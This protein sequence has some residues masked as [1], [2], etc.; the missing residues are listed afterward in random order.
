MG[1]VSAMGSVKCASQEGQG[2]D[3]MLDISRLQENGR[4]IVER[5]DSLV[6]LLPKVRLGFRQGLTGGGNGLV[7]LPESGKSTTEKVGT[8]HEVNVVITS[9]ANAQFVS[10]QSKCTLVVA[11]FPDGSGKVRE[12]EGDVGMVRAK[13]VLGPSEFQAAQVVGFRIL[14]LMLEKPRAVD[15]TGDGPNVP[16]TMDC[17]VDG[18][19]LSK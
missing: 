10:K 18:Q 7:V 11:Q 8:P 13:D 14:V 1:R 19:S 17:L 15:N 5:R 16:N 3:A 4:Q 9:L 6:V 2:L 12:E